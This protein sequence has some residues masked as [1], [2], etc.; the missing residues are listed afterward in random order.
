MNAWSLGLACWIALLVDHY[1]G[2]PALR[3]HPVVWM[4]YYLG[5]AGNR[6]QRHAAQD[7][8][9]PDLRTFWRGALAWRGRACPSLATHFRWK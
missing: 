6:V 7:P 5:G 4:G 3:Y 2:E 9:Q 8:Q 1:L